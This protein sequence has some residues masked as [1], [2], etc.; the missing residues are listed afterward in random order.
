MKFDL[1]S[2]P[3]RAMDTIKKEQE[4]EDTSLKVIDAT[5]LAKNSYTEYSRYVSCGRAYPQVI[6][7]AK[8]SYRRAIYG[9]YKGQGQKKMKVAEL[10]A[11]ALPYHPHPTSVSGVII[12]LGEAG[13]K[14]KLMDTQGNWGD[15]S[16]GVEASADRYIEGRLSDLAQKL[17]CD[18]VEYAEMVPGEIDKPEPRALPAYIPLCFINGSSGIPSGLPTLNIPPL[19]ILG[20]FDYYIDVLSHKDLNYVPKKV[21]LPN[22]EVDILST[23][24]EWNTI[25][26]T[27]KGSLKVAPRIEID[28]NNVITITSLP[29]T[30]SS[31]HIRKIIEKEILLDKVDFRDESAKEI[32][33]VIEKVPHKQVDMKELY[34]RLYTKLQSS[35]TYNMAFFDDEK[36]YVPCSF[37][38]VVKENI[39]YLIA[40]HKNRTTIQLEQNRLK[41][42][43]LEI[44]ED[45]KKKNNFKE[46]FQLDTENAIDYI[47]DRYK[48]EKDIASKVLQKPLSYL[49]REHLQE[50]NDLKDLISSLEK[51][52]SDMYEFL[53]TR[54]KALK[55]EVAKVI[56]DKFKPT[57]FVNN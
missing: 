10:S 40:T 13:N 20:M 42:R 15:S 41:L 36:I 37:H 21:P 53:C 46:I 11:F 32:R 4:V 8:S 52:N 45:M 9:M 28:K 27:G 34:N 1:F 50:L 48:V 24:E 18:S 38:K 55:K 3:V 39:K 22:L 16:R 30:K 26:K 5:E 43:V 35:V 47:C 7:G 2:E 25:L 23:K 51:D 19:D 12:Q 54:Y 44:I 56:K 29:E 17:F 33:Y 49:T 6:D 57:V 14:L 31:D